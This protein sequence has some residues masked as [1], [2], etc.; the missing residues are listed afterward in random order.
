MR[1]TIVVL[2]GYGGTGKLI[3]RYLLNETDANVIVAG[4]SADKAKELAEALNN[5]FAGQRTSSVFADASDHQS[6]SRAFAGVTVV[7]DATIAIPHVQTIAEQALAAGADFLDFHFEQKIVSLLR[8]MEPRIKAAGRCFITQA[9]F[10]PGLPSAFIRYAAPF[11]DFYEKAV[12]GM[13]MN[14]KIEKA[15]SIYELVDLLADYKV[16]I[17]K[18]GAWKTAGSFD[19]KKFDFGT[20]FGRRTCYPIPMEEIRAMPE[21]FGLEETGVYVAGFNWFVDYLVFPLAFLLFKIRKGLGRETI[22]KLLL[23]GMNTFSGSQQGVSFVLEAD[24]KKTGNLAHVRVIAEHDDAYA[25]TAIPV[26]ACIR[27]YL[28]GHIVKP[29]LWLM[30]HVVEPAGLIAD[31]I[32]MGI[33]VR[34]DAN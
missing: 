3:C 7:L 10:H 6:L 16:D 2:G 28:D 32:R 15:E 11:F 12:I 13:A 8:D 17:F 20:R 33:A 29:G 5:E 23:W 25:F 14:Q 1:Q 31:M 19:Y 34:M 18:N 26:V 9:G 22:A 27:Q 4:R 21:M 30:G 24:G